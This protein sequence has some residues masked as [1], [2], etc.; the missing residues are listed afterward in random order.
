MW[1]GVLGLVSTGVLDPRWPWVWSW[2]L[3][4]TAGWLVVTSA[5]P[6]LSGGAPPRLA[7]DPA[8]AVHGGLL[9]LHRLP[10][11]GSDPPLV[12]SVSG[13]SAG[14]CSD[15]SRGMCSLATFRRREKPGRG[16]SVVHQ[17][18]KGSKRV[19]DHPSH[20]AGEEKRS[21]RPRVRHGITPGPKAQPGLDSGTPDSA[22]TLSDELPSAP[23]CS[24]FLLT[25]LLPFSPLH[26]M[27]YLMDE[28]KKCPQSKLVGGVL[29]Q[30][31]GTPISHPSFGCF[32]GARH[33]SKH[34]HALSHLN[35]FLIRAESC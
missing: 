18:W 2:G 13:S 14:T 33:C 26:Q 28:I 32:L 10:L 15:V 31:P 22:L 34:V 30:G 21:Q 29:I 12:S 7:V 5:L 16:D 19:S 23:P 3:D 6:L 4:S 25:S 11:P 20:F 24:K 17:R 35:P 8:A 27:P 9:P 1:T